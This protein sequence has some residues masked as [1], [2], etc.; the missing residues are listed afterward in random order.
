M[1]HLSLVLVLALGASPLVAQDADPDTSVSFGVKGDA[2]ARQEWTREIPD[3]A[4]P[5]GFRNDDR[6]RLELRP[7]IDV[8][9]K[10]LRLGV[11]GAFD[12]STDT[13]VTDPRPTLIRDNYDAKARR[14]DLAFARLKPVSWL[15]AE[16][17]RMTMPVALTEMIWDRDLR[18]QGGALT[19]EARDLGSVQRLGVTAVLAKGSHVFEDGP[20][21][22]LIVSGNLQVATGPDSHFQALAS[23]VT[24]THLDGLE[25]MIRRQ[26]T[27]VLDGPLAGT[28]AFDYKIVDGVARLT[29]GGAGK[30]ALQLVA[31]Y[32]WNTAIDANNKGLWLAAALGSLET[33]GGRLEYTFARVDKDATVAAYATDDFFWETG[34]QGHRLDLGLRTSDK[35]SI[36]GIGQLQK[37]KDSPVVSQ[38]D[39]NV[40]RFRVELRVKL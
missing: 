9:L 15:T 23:Y 22:M 5:S 3:P 34:W 26:N 28:L 36:H 20:T 37:F 32:C 10:W 6:R 8:G 11:G 7:R 25:P 18:P 16:G 12:F 17:G 1:R 33:A 35:S 30:F 27:R 40:K 13:N 21:R 31:D 39:Q 24:F 29:T 14:L 19:L 4:Q 2:L 38:R